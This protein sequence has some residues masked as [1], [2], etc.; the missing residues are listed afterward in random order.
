MSY[1]KVPYENLKKFCTDV[2][3]GYGYSQEESEDIVDVLLQADLFGIE[4]HG[5]QRLIRYHRSLM[6]GKIPSGCKSVR[7]F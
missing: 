6:Q 4:S 2:F 7:D 3:K 1:R 5:V